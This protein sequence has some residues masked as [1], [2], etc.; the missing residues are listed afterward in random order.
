LQSEQHDSTKNTDMLSI[1]HCIVKCHVIEQ[2]NRILSEMNSSGLHNKLNKGEKH[3]PLA[4][5][6]DL[7]GES[8][9]FSYCTY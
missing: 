5:D 6:Q 7:P 8:D 4:H 3:Q 2:L 9:Y 1:V